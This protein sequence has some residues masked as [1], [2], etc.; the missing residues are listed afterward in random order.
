VT[1][2][3]TTKEN[4]MP[5]YEKLKSLA[6]TLPAVTP[7]VAAFVPSVRSGNLLFISGHIAKKD[8]RPWTGQ[9]GAEITT[10]E[11]N[12]AARGIAID[13]MGAL[14]A[15]TGNLDSIR[16]IV[17]LLV[18]VNSTPTFNEQHLVANGASE[19]LAEVFGDRGNHARSAFGVVQIP[20]GACVEIELIAEVA[21]AQSQP[22]GL[23]AAFARDAG[24][25]SDKFTGLARVMSGKYDWK[26]AQGVRSVADVFNL[27]VKENGLLAG[28]LAGTPNPGAA[29][30]SITDPGD[31]QE[32]LKAAYLNLQGA[33]AAL[34]DNDLQA[35]VKLFGKDMTKQ[36]ALMLILQDQ[37]EHL[38]Q[39][40][41]YARGNG[42]AP[43]WSK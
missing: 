29:P 3:V 36:S 40:I 23:Q 27:I 43:P 12:E 16:R 42:V 22:A 21:D 5:A 6:I 14:E 9:L 35:P 37:H 18:L 20:F 34:S 15:A 10:A 19:L 41:A 31:M 13:L 39:A 32:A 7:P 38:G 28:A 24:A 25:L 17:K 4:D 30:A 1:A 33:I 11:G 2:A 8:G 26:P